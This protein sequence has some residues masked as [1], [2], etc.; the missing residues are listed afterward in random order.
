[1]KLYAKAWLAL[2]LAALPAVS[3][4]GAAPERAEATA[5]VRIV[6]DGEP[7]ETDAQPFIRDGSTL[8]PFRALFER[9]G[10]TVEWNAAS[11]TITGAGK[12]VSIALQVGSTLASVNGELKTLS[13]APDIVDGRAFVPLRFVGESA[14]ATV[15]WSADT[16]TVTVKSGATA[17]D[18]EAA[19]IAAYEAY[20]AESNREDVAAV[21]ALLHPDSRLRAFLRPALADSFARRDV[22]TT[23]ESIEATALE[24]DAAELR[25]AERHER[26]GGA[27]FLDRESVV[28][29]TLR[30]GKDGGWRLYDVAELDV[31]WLRPF[32]EPTEGFV[33]GAADAAAAENTI[34]SYMEAL[35]QE[36]LSEALGWIH[37]DAPQRPSTEASLRHMFSS[38]DLVH[39][40]E[41]VRVLDVSGDEM[42]VYTVQSMRKTAGPKLAD[43]RTETIHT[44]RRQ[45]D[46]G[47]RIYSTIRGGTETL[48]IPQ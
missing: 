29:A 32:G 34:A 4:V 37:A 25:V 38:Y 33:A 14:R 30:K 8:L 15:E 44:L 17:A 41:T 13:A 6:F 48:S 20:V 40:L 36:N 42:T 28:K 18:E 12:G 24:A 27:F 7:L 23:I 26:R 16:R 47:W 21:E 2:A 19:A 45:G 11:R 1:M 35:N 22:G 5:T 9:L 3:A 46:A 10:L 43:A 39:A 31:R